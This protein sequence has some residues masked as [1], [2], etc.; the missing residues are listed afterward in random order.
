V[1]VNFIKYF[2]KTETT[3]KEKNNAKKEISNRFSIGDHFG[4]QTCGED[5]TKSHQL[6]HSVADSASRERSGLKW[7]PIIIETQRQW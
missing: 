6:V 3:S 1:W 2:N 4:D 7:S 5:I